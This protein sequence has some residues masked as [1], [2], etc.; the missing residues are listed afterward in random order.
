AASRE[1]SGGAR[2]EDAVEVDRGARRA[3]AHAGRPG[4][5]EVQG[6]AAA[7]AQGP[8]VAPGAAGVDTAAAAAG[9]EGAAVGPGAS[10]KAVSVQS[11]AIDRLH[12]PLVDPVGALDVD[13]TPADIGADGPLID[14]GDVAGVAPLTPVAHCAVAATHRDPRPNR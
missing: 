2:V 10:L 14:D 7:G 3:E 13:V 1:G 11:G 5:V 4:A 9:A 12:G 8:G 6:G